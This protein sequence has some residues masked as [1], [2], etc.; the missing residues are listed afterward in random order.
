MYSKNNHLIWAFIT[1]FGPAVN[2]FKTKLNI[3]PSEPEP[4]GSSLLSV[5]ENI[6]GDLTT[7]A[8]RSRPAHIIQKMIG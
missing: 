4:G 3:C 5:A 8:A 2:F 1:V 6:R 7:A